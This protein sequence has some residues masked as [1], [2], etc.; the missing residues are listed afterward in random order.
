MIE[1]LTGTICLLATQKEL[2]KHHRGIVTK[3]SRCIHT[4]NVFFIVHK[5]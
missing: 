4:P 1:R 2:L 3:Q 5:Q